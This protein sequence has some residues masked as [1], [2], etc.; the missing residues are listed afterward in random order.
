MLYRYMIGMIEMIL[1][2]LTGQSRESVC[3]DA[4][5][6]MTSKPSRVSPNTVVELGAG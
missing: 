2:S 3:A 4:M 6:S 1:M 5:R